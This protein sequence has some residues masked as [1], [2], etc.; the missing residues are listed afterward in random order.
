MASSSRFPGAL[1]IILYLQFLCNVALAQNET[2][3]LPGFGDTVQ[4]LG[5]VSYATSSVLP[6]V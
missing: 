5:A 2:Q 3:N 6:V 4:V 1:V